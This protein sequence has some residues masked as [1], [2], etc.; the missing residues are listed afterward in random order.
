MNPLIY[1][2]IVLEKFADQVCKRV[3]NRVVAYLRGIADTLSGDDSSLKNAWEEICAQVQFEHSIY[4]DVYESMIDQAI[5]DYV[6]R[7]AEHEL[8]AVWFQTSEGREW[9]FT[10][11]ED[12][13]EPYIDR[14][15]VVV[16]IRDWVLSKAGNYTN[17]RIRK[18]LERFE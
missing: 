14:Q 10:E 4:W 18:Y 8:A 9:G 5:E 7:L 16:L 3:C 2:W 11:C 15:E 13:K 1:E 17:P 6:N 12:R